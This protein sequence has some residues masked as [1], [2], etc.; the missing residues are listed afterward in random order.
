MGDYRTSQEFANVY[1][2]LLNGIPLTPE[3]VESLTV[4]TG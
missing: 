2:L 3:I 1:K 4:A